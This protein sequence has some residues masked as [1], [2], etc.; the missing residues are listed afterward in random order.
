MPAGVS[1]STYLKF[2]ASATISMMVGAQAVHVIYR[3]L[4]DMDTLVEAEINRI[5]HSNV[6]SN[7][8]EKMN[9]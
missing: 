9:G 6:V 5:K 3:P 4:A 2:A 1:W 7:T 8:N